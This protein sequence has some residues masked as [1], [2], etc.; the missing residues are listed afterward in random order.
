MKHKNKNRK[1]NF[2]YTLLCHVIN[3]KIQKNNFSIT[4]S[5]IATI[6]P[7][8]PI[9]IWV[10]SDLLKGISLGFFFG[11]IICVTLFD[12]LLKNDKPE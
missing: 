7:Q 11:L 3:F 8:I 12:N 2:L 4:K 9:F 1:S 5:A 6:I 10:D